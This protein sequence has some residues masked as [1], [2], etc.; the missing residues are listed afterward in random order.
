MEDTGTWINGILL[1]IVF[2]ESAVIF[3]IWI[4]QRLLYGNSLPKN[5]NPKSRFF[6][7]NSRDYVEFVL[8]II[9]LL[10]VL[11]FAIFGVAPIYLAVTNLMN[12]NGVAISIPYI[13]IVLAFI[14][15]TV[16]LAFNGINAINSVFIKV[17]NRNQANALHARLDNIENALH[18]SEIQSEKIEN[19]KTTKEILDS[20]ESSKQPTV[21]MSFVT[22]LLL[23]AFLFFSSLFLLMWFPTCE[24]TN[25][26]IALLAGFVS[27]GF[28][29]LVQKLIIERK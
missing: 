27:G 6:G 16:T 5:K 4:D 3:S 28:I 14:A 18:C 10:I 8:G 2:F 13:S 20:D 7:F 12:T 9:F 26:S 21:L 11:W 1:A 25:I 15:I 23:A 17:T 24:R 19:K 29:L 22:V